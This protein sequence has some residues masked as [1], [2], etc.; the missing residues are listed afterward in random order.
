MT[1]EFASHFPFDFN[2][3]FW[4]FYGQQSLGIS[5]PVQ[6][7]E[8]QYKV[9]VP[10][11]I[12]FSGIAYWMKGM[13]FPTDIPIQKAINTTLRLI[14][15]CPNTGDTLVINY[16]GGAHIAL[17]FR[18]SEG[19]RYFSFESPS[20]RRNFQSNNAFTTKQAQFINSDEIHAIVSDICQW[21]DTL[22]Q[23][24][25]LL[26]LHL[27][28]TGSMEKT[29][30]EKCKV[31]DIALLSNNCASTTLLL[32]KAGFDQVQARLSHERHFI[33]TPL[34]TFYA[35]KELSLNR[36]QNLL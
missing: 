2:S 13:L 29:W 27:L 18:T 31:A 11:H 30:K 25:N 4:G 8:N 23:S 7:D 6:F 24:D 20:Q 14:D 35:A 10:T 16:C 5:N 34:N 3:P 28:D 12:P 9:S 22:E 17:L 36:E 33:Q 15:K 21:C 1:L 19:M 32:L 26:L